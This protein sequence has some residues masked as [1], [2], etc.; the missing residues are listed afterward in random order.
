MD[1]IA[2]LPV[3]AATI[4]NNQFREGELR[5]TRGVRN[6]YRCGGATASVFH[7]PFFKPSD[8]GGGIVFIH[9]DSKNDS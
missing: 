9:R 8:V 1:L 4:Y 2:K 3:V 7:L 5:C 6:T